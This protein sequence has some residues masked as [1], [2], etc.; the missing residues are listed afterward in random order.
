MDLRRQALRQKVPTSGG[1][2]AGGKSY[3]PVSWQGYFDERVVTEDGFCIYRAGQSGPPCIFLH[4]AGHSALSWALVASIMR[5]NCRIVAY[6]FRGHGGSTIDEQDLSSE[7]LVQDTIS[8]IDRTFGE[9]VK[10]TIVGHSM[11]GAIAI[12]TASS[13][14]PSRVSSLVVL[15]VVEGSAMEALPRMKSIL[16]TRPKSFESVSDAIKWT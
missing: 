7:T 13:L 11:G 9:G 5:A 3:E 16:A 2:G 12:R 15:D 8:V 4:G 14:G 1:R 6:D 10:V